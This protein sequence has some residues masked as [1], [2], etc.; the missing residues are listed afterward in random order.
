MIIL[1]YD[2]SDVDD[3]VL[4]VLDESTMA[5][6]DG[7]N[8]LW[9]NQRSRLAPRRYTLTGNKT[10]TIV[11]PDLPVSWTTPGTYVR[12]HYVKM[13]IPVVNT[14]DPIDISIP[15]YYQE[16]IRYLAVAY[17]L[18]NDTD[19]KSSQLKKEMAEAFG[20]HMA[21]GVEKLA[22]GEQDA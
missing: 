17:L 15:D 11:P 18:E 2:S 21:A 8:E 19:L 6:E 14:T 9:R 10:F 7:N 3:T 1:G 12:M 16:A 4:R 22:Q 5:F 20:Y 13:A